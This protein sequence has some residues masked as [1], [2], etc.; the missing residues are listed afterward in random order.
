M[1]VDDHP[2]V[3]EWFTNLINEEPDLK[4]CGVAGSKREAL[5]LIGK[6]S[7]QLLVVDI[8]MEGGSG[9]ELIKDIKPLHPEVLVIVLSMHDE[10]L[11]AE[12]AMRAG[13]AGYLMKSEATHKVIAAI[14]TVL[15]GG[16]SFG[17]TVHARLAQKMARGNAQAPDAT[18]LLS[19]RE[20]EIYLLL[21][22][23]FNTRQ[24]S[25]ELSIGF[26]TVHVYCARIRDKLHLNSINQLVLHAVRRHERQQPE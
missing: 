11:Y 25:E 26:K 1:L 9:L 21:G 16:V 7:P 14:R 24:V 17:N 19:D 2:L 23:G 18:A 15:A 3:R 12:R 5:G 20:L 22:R 8:S 13:A 4:V 10:Q 6:C